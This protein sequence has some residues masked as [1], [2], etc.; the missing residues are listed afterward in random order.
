VDA[1][2]LERDSA[3]PSLRR[4]ANEQRIADA[5]GR[6]VSP[7]CDKPMLSDLASAT[8]LSER[9]L[10]R[11]LPTV[12]RQVSPQIA[13]TFREVLLSLKLTTATALLARGDLT[14]NE[15]ARLVG[16]GS[17][18]ALHLAMESAGMPSPS[19]VLSVT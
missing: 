2:L 15:V 16:Y 4:E 12:W 8:G 17:S 1:G 9:H 7:L 5:L 3:F 11:E 6:V 13:P 14:V 10:R 19:R 18:R